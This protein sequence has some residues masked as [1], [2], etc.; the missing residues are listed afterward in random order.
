M[1]RLIELLMSTERTSDDEV[2]IIISS[3][4]LKHKKKKINSDY[5]EF[6][7]GEVLAAGEN[8]AVDSCKKLLETPPGSSNTHL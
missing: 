8:T 4:L 2:L 1:G 7:P 6:V 3:I 5:V